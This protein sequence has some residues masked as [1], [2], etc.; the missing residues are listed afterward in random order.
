[1]EVFRGMKA[2]APNPLKVPEP[3]SLDKYEVSQDDAL[4]HIIKYLYGNQVS[5]SLVTALGH[6]SDCGGHPRD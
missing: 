6:Q 1:M 3:A 5:G 2:N 4:S